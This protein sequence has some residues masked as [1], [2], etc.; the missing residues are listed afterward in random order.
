M[1]TSIEGDRN[2][3]AQHLHLHSDDAEPIASR[4]ID[5]PRP[6]VRYCAGWTAT[7]IAGFLIGIHAGVT[8]EVAGLYATILLLPV[9][10][11]IARA[12]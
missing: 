3:I 11:A 7:V 4:L 2:I 1:T 8:P 10:F 12:R 9:A 6:N 5:P